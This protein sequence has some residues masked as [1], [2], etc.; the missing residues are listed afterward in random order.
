MKVEQKGSSKLGITALGQAGQ[1]LCEM[2]PFLLVFGEV[3]VFGHAKIG[4][5]AKNVK[6]EWGG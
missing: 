5:T 3:F 4:A 2:A 1:V 6:R